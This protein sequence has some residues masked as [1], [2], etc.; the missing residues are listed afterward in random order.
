MKT[1]TAANFRNLDASQRSALKNICRV[2][3]ERFTESASTFNGLIN[4]K[5]D[6]NAV[7]QI[8]GEGARRLSQ[9][10]EE[11]AKEAWDFVEALDAVENEE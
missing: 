5:P 10:F 1:P 8:H 7:M 3:A 2:A 11:Q 6:P 4:H 9:Q